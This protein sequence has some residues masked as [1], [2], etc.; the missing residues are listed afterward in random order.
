[1]EVVALDRALESLADRGPRDLDLVAGLEAPDGDVI[2]DLGLGVLLILAPLFVPELDQG[3]RGR[4]AGLL[5]VPELALG[6][7]A[8]ADLVE[9]ELDGVVA[10]AVGLADRG[11]LAW[12]GLDHGHRDGG[13]VFGEDLGHAELLADDR[14][15]RT[16]M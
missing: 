2:A 15:H 14:G 16:P 12:P 11:H 5:Q 3:P 9:G 8:L 10:I 13:A 1:G 6:E 7:L 4:R